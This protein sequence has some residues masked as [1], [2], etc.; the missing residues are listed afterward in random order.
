MTPL[1]QNPVVLILIDEDGNPQRIASNIDPN[2]KVIV[3]TNPHE[4]KDESTN[5]PFVN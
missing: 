3:T 4:F 5:K 1:P 2:L